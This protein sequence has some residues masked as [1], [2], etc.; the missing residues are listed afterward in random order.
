MPGA[1]LVLSR[2][3]GLPLELYVAGEGPPLVLLPPIWSTAP[4]WR[5]QIERLSAHH[6]VIVP[7]YP[8]YGR[9]AFDP[10][11]ATPERVAERLMRALDDLGHGGAFAVIG[12]SLGG[13]VAQRLAARHPE[14]VRALVL[15]NTTARLDE[16]DSATRGVELLSG[17]VADF[18]RGLLPFGP[19]TQRAMRAQLEQGGQA[20][21]SSLLMHYA[22]ETLRFDA[23]AEL[24]LI[25][26]PTLII[27]GAKDSLTPPSLGRLLYERIPGARYVELREGGHYV[28]LQHPERFNQLVE[29][30]L[31]VLAP[32]AERAVSGG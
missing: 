31:R 19:A 14:R 18:E 24:G 5:A 10:S 6:A 25:R 15:V 30:H 26:A 13:M 32:S 27:Q 29:E 4:I 28:P 20:G 22:S 16:D 21:P 12:W 1:R 9:S 11:V 2:V 7:H 17:L 3:D 8:G 23:R